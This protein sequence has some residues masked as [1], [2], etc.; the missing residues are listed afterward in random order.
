[1]DRIDKI[2]SN[3]AG[4]SR[5][6]AKLYIKNGRVKVNGSVVK[7]A[8][9]KVNDSDLVS[10]DGKNINT[11]KFRYFMLNKPAGYI[12][13]TEQEPGDN[14]PNVIS[15]FK[16][17]GVKGLFPVGRLDK[18]TTGLLIITNDG[19]LGHR[20]TA[21]G[22][23]VDKVYLA[24]VRGILAEDAVEAFEKGFKFK[25]FISAPAKLEILDVEN[26]STE[27]HDNDGVQEINK[28]VGYSLAR[29][30]IHEGKF[31]QVKRMFQKVGCEVVELKR[32]S[33]GNMVLDERLKPG[34]YKELTAEEIAVI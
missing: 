30:T 33:M 11:C 25:E 5:A 10:M 21:P 12:S 2:L 28:H 22:K 8:G 17:E 15:L 16:N 1:M 34:E 19:E 14:S 32:V 18:D 20:L 27:K 6:E 26:Q 29:V 31:H 9:L 7:D 24:K 13:S 3:F 4:L 23:H